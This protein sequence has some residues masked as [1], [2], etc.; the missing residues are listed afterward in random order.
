M[1]AMDHEILYSLLPMAFE[2]YG[3]LATGVMMVNGSQW[4]PGSGG[5]RRAALI[6]QER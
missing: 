5:L 1:K 2:T 4:E 3:Q 6:G